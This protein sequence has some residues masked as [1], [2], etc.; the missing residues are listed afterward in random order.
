MASLG[1]F[2]L[3]LGGLLLL[4]AF[5]KDAYAIFAI[6]IFAALGIAV[7]G[8]VVGLIRPHWVLPARMA[9][10]RMAVLGVY[11]TLLMVVLVIFGIIGTVVGPETE[12]SDPSGTRI[13]R[14]TT[15]D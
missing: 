7:V 3:E 14:G 5:F 8:L 1:R 12:S 10:S 6:I 13:E 4:Y 15:R 11:F 9:P 2:W